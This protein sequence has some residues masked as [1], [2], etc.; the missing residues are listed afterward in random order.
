LLFGKKHRKNWPCGS[1]QIQPH[2]VVGATLWLELKAGARIGAGTDTVTEGVG[3][4]IRAENRGH[5]G[6]PIPL[7]HLFL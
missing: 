5:L 4:A 3:V 2:D 6:R 1:S 7:T